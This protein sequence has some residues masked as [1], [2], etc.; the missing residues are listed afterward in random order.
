MHPLGTHLGHPQDVVAR[1]FRHGDD[2]IG[3]RQGGLLDPH[4][5]VVPATQ[6]FALPRPQRLERVDGDHQRDPV[7]LLDQHAAHVRV[8]RVAVHQVGIDVVVRPGDVALHGAVDRA[9]VCWGARLLG[10]GVAAHAQVRL[11]DALIAE[12]A[13]LDVHQAG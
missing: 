10:F 13:H 3:H 1:A 12:A 7:A 6:L 11:I 9:Q 4:R 2:P 8:P 5:Q